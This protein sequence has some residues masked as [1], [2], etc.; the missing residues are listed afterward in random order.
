MSANDK[1]ILMEMLDIAIGAMNENELCSYCRLYGSSLC[2]KDD[3]ICVSGIFTGLK[4]QAE[5]RLKND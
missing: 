3:D 2:E 5:K 4:K 1:D